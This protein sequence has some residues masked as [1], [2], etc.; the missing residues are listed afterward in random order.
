[1]PSMTHVICSGESVG[2]READLNGIPADD[3]TRAVRGKSASRICE[4]ALWPPCAGVPLSD[5]FDK[6]NTGR[7]L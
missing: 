6:D 5:S 3:A 7:D 1:M 2:G 4:R